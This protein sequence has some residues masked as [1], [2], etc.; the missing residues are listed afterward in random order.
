MGMNKVLFFRLARFYRGSTWK[1]GLLLLSALTLC[2][3]Q[4]AEADSSTLEAQWQALEKPTISGSTTAPETLVVGRA[5]IRPAPGA[6]LWLMSVGDRR[7]GYVLDGD[8]ELTYRVEDS[9]S[10]APARHNLKKAD[11]FKIE[12]TGEAMVLTTRLTGAAVWGWDI[13]LDE[14]AAQQTGRELPSW[15]QELSKK[16]YSP[17]PARDLL[18]IDQNGGSGY[19]WALFRAQGEDLMLDVDP[20]PSS[21]TESLMRLARAARRAVGPFAGR[22]FARRLVTQPIDRP[23]SQAEPIDFLSTHT[24]IDVKNA[25]KNHVRVKTSTRLKMRRDGLRLLPMALVYGTVSNGDWKDNHI[26]SLTVDGRPTPYV[27]KYGDLLVQLPRASKKGDTF[28]LEV[29]T[30]GEILVRPAGDN[31][32]RLG[33]EPWYPKPN[34]GGREWAEFEISA[35]VQ[36][37]YK[38]FAGGQILESENTD[39]T[40]RVKTHLKGPMRTAMVVAGKY[41]T[42]TK[43]LDDARLHISSYATVKKKSAERLSQIMFSVMDCLGVWLGVPYPFQDLQVVELN[44]W[45]WAQAPP[46]LI[47]I[48]QEA[49][50]T[51]ASAQV[52]DEIRETIAAFASRGINERVSHEVAH[53]WFP[54]VAK[55]MRSEEGWLS[56]SLADYASAV[57]LL[58]RS[59]DK[60]KGQELFDRQVREWHNRSKDAGDATSVYLAGHLASSRD[61][62]S[63]RRDLL[64]GRGPLVLHA[65]RLQLQKKHGEEE[66]DRL[67]LTW[68]RSYVT[69][70]T[71]KPAETRYLIQIL[72]QVTGEPWQPFFDRYIYG[73]EGPKI[74]L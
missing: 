33:G 9:L 49:F 69:N 8:A 68:I 5:E 34:V 22:R 66:G 60:K 21:A 20:R 59:A 11:G 50:M 24:K 26:V 41:R 27:F 43:E 15:L 63:I 40:S 61:N 7:V 47:F 35:E 46:G 55:V 58:Q 70:F 57:C 6:R 13:E 12:E 19:R 72:E 1:A 64:Y 54:H 14:E 45:G 38:V 2:A 31:Y 4:P 52:G 65:I 23:W 25:E 53:A 39:E 28:L 10:R 3:S 44:Q 51:K 56:E 18:S 48:T 37:P 67:F 73:P 42:H 32:W 29:E 62:A 71:Y 16:K 74:K 36:A 30:E 17:N